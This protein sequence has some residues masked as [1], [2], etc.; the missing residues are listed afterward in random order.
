MRGLLDLAMSPRCPECGARHG[1]AQLLGFGRNVM[2]ALWMVGAL[3][4]CATLLV[5]AML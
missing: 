4:L 3:A 5:G 2:L 1:L